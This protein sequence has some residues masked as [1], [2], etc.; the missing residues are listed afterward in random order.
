MRSELDRRFDGMLAAVT[1]PG[2][3]LVLDKDE[4]GR[5]I[6]ANFPPTLPSFFRTF[7]ALAGES[8]AI[9][10]GE[11]RLNFADL[12]RWSEQLARSLAGR[13]IKKGDRVGIAMRNCPSWV[14]SYMA[15][16]KAGGIATRL[17]G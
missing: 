11:E 14:V 15:F 5:A 17:N 7:C 6:V 16:V 2:G 13:G 4:Q 1:G 12:D 8:E 9:V 10:A 3:R